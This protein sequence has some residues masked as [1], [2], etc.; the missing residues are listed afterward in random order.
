M[1]NGY[2][3]GL[4][5]SGGSGVAS[6]ISGIVT[7]SPISKEYP[8][9]ANGSLHHVV[10]IVASAVTVAGA[11]TAKL[12]TAIGS[13]WVDSKTVS[14][15]AAGNFYIKLNVEVAGDQT[16]LPLLNKGRIVITSTNAGDAATIDAIYKLQDE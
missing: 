16:F 5:I 14:I 3:A 15:T 8:I 7:N 9:T 12:Q 4:S 13:D 10:K 11:I 6:S 2:S 1:P